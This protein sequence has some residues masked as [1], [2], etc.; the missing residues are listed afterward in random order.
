MSEP[1]ITS[2]ANPRVRSWLRLRERRERDRAR[3]TLVD[4]LTEI[5]RALTAGAAVEEAIVG[6]TAADSPAAQALVVRL[7]A[8]GVTIV[9]VSGAVEARLGFG[10]RAEGV[11]AVVAVPSLTLE[12][13]AL[14]RDPL[15]LVTE[16]VE[17]PGN[18]GALLRTAD[19]VGADAVIA[20]DPRTDLYN[21]NAIRA[22]LGTI[23][24]LHLAAAPS[25]AVLSWCRAHGLRLVAARVDGA[26]AHTAADLRGPLAILLGSEADGLSD[27]WT[28]PDVL[29]VRLPMLGV[30]DS[31]NVSV[32]GA[33][34]LFEA[35]RQRASGR[36]PA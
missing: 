36:R 20:A 32:A 34:L 17:K 29:T 22:S 21:P 23:F 33:V 7:R 5:G 4:G 14:P 19:G 18:L 9:T 28:G 15:V 8:A 1:A 30:A 16:G 35:L 26:V 24:S 3:R 12:E 25:A 2:L 11:V 6:P 13:L 27:T 10:D 31:L